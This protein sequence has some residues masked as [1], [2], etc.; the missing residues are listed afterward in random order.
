MK[1]TKLKVDGFKNLT[2]VEINPHE[3]TNI[4]FGKNAQ[5]KTN[6][7]ES[8][9]LMSGA[10]SFR[11]TKDKDLIKI[12]QDVMNIE[13]SYS[14]KRRNQQIKVSVSR[15]N[16][17]DKKI[18]LN[19]VDVKNMSGLFGNISCVVFTPEDLE[20]SKGSPDI[21][22]D[23]VDLSISQIK[24]SYADI[25]NRYAETLHQRNA[26][27]KNIVYDN[28]GQELL[29]IYDSSLA[30]MGCYITSIRYKYIKKLSAVANE[31]YRKISGGKEELTLSYVSTVFPQL[32]GKTG[33]LTDVSNEYVE[34]LRACREN[35]IRSG[36]T[37]VGVHRDDIIARINGLIA[38]DYAS[39]GQHRSIALCL[40]LAQAYILAQEQSD[41]PIILLDDILSELDKERQ[42]FV[43][44]QI[45]NMQ[46]FIT[47]CDNIPLLGVGRVFEIEGGK[48]K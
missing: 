25:A 24:N 15:Q 41:S 43:L 48:I 38:R 33:T 3:Y 4:L 36:F 30:S 47:C 37:T 44:S 17:R 18:T 34:A 35:D 23:F 28:A 9:W 29:Q 12:G 22:R 19:G 39:Q 40:K 11:S 1:I 8:I 21:R 6:L 5:G 16:I 26:V 46:V 32:E 7:I 20:I 31:L 13:L 27:L 14:D 10:R 2:G 45:E 42:N